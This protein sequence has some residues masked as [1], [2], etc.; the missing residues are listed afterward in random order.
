[1]HSDNGE[2]DKQMNARKHM[3][4]IKGVIKTSEIR[5][6]QYNTSTKMMDVEFNNGKRYPYSYSSIEWLKEPQVLNPNIYRISKAGHNFV[7]IKAIYVFRGTNDS[8]WHICFDDGSE[9]DYSQSELRIVESCLIQAE[10]E[11]VFKYI[12]QIADLSEIKNEKTSE[13]LLTKQFNK[14]AFLDND[15]VLAKYLN[16]SLLQQNHIEHKYVPIFPFGCNKS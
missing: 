3:I 4:I 5:S 6:C 11:N 14:I 1:M 2:S 12:K 9:R 15:V 13:K 16:P 8:Y 10:T 7:G